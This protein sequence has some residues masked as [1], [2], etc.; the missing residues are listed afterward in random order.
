MCCNLPHIARDMMTA[1]HGHISDGTIDV[2]YSRGQPGRIKL[3]RAMVAM[4]DGEHFDVDA[5][6]LEYLK[7]TQLEVAPMEGVVMIDGEVMPFGTVRATPLQ[8]AINIVRSGLP[9]AAS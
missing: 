3:L 2:V 4:E 8:A 7:V 1:P 6:F 9:S 5:E